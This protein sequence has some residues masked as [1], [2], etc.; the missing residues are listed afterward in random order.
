MWLDIPVGLGS[1]I[2]G[3]KPKLSFLG[4]FLLSRPQTL[5]RSFP[6]FFLSLL[7]FLFFFFFV[8]AGGEK[9]KP[10]FKKKKSTPPLFY[11]RKQL[12]KIYITKQ[13]PTKWV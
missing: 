7:F 1:Q 2:L 13:Q 8:A 5:S 11:F 4:D 9:K 10:N 12:E 3:Y 6:I